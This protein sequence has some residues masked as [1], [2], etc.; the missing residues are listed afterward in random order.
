[1]GTEVPKVCPDTRPQLVRMHG[2]VHRAVADL[3]TVHSYR[4]TDLISNK[5]IDEFVLYPLSAPIDG[6][7]G[8]MQMEIIELQCDGGLKENYSKV[9]LFGFRSKYTGLNT[10]SAVQFTP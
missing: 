4:L 10:F 3:G 9:V 6:V 5:K 8:N 1:M 7:S 2:R